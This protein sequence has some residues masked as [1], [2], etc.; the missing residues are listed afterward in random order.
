MK[1]NQSKA[2]NYWTILVVV[3]CVIVFLAD[4][5]VHRHAH[6]KFESWPGFYALFGFAAYVFIV[7]S[8]K[9]LRR[10]IQRKNNYYDDADQ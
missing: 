8:A 4:F 3:A 2:A 6:F 9:Q 1:T 5:I 10:L 7:L